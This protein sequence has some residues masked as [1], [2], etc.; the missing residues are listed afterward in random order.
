MKSGIRILSLGCAP[1]IKK[2][3]LLVGIVSRDN[4]IEGVLSTYVEVDGT[5]ATEKIKRLFKK[6]RFRDQ[7]KIIA[8]NGLGLAGLNILDVFDLER[9]LKV[10]VV[11][12][13]RK[14]PHP[15]ELIKALRAFSKETKIDVRSRIELVKNL[16]KLNIVKID[17]F[18]IQT[19][20]DERDIKRFIVEIFNMLRLVHMIA[21]GV[22]KGESRNRI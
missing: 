8:V 20:A 14:K 16:K 2:K 4:N 22:T 9:E 11:S 12:L 1:L 18:Y 17:R 6:S 15:N 13:T 19:S 21:S 5:D 3:T 7:I 10:K